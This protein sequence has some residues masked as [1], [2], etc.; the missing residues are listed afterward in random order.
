MTGDSGAPENGAEIDGEKAS[1]REAYVQA[2]VEVFLERGYA[3][4][5]VADIVKRAGGGSLT[6]LYRTFDSKEV[7]FQAVVDSRV[8]ALTAPL[9]LDGLMDV[10]LESGLRTI[11]EIMLRQ[12]S[13]QTS[14]QMF[15][16]MA[17][18]A[19]MFP[20]MVNPFSIQVPERVRRAVAV[21]IRARVEAGDMEIEDCERASG[22]FLDLVR[23][24]LSIRGLM[25]KSWVPTDEEITQFV[26]TAVIFFMRGARGV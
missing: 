9:K 18:A 1:R 4:A 13:S 22:A 15:R 25:D 21:Y 12:L 3:K 5:S 6:T 19:G 20:D 14:L 24:R 23:A 7:L 16:L 17:E 10:P 8:A 11:G 26:D 2:A